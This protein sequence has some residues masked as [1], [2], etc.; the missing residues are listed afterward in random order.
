M[1]ILAALAINTFTVTRVPKSRR[2]T[3]YLSIQDGSSPLTPFERAHAAGVEG[4]INTAWTMK[5]PTAASLKKLTAENLAGLGPVR[6]A[7]ILLD[8]AETRP[9][10]KRRL[11]M[12]VAAEQGAEH[13]AP[14]IDKRL[15]SVQTSRGKIT[16][17]QKPAVV[18]DLDALRGLIAER[19]AGLDRSAALDRIWLFLETASS[20]E[21]RLRDRDGALSDVYVR[22]AGDLGRLLAEHD[23]QIGAHALIDAVAARP[24]AWGEWLPAALAGLPRAMAQTALQLALERQGRTPGWLTALRSLSDAAGDIQAFRATYTAEALATPG[25]AVEVARRFLAAQVV[26]EAGQVLRGAAPSPDRRGRL[27]PPNFDWETAWIDYL[28]ASGDAEAAQAVRWASFERT[29]DVER[30]R[31]FV[32][33]LDGFDD[34]EAENRAF[35]LAASTESFQQGLSFLMA[36][37]ALPEASQM[38]QARESEAVVDAP[39]AEVWAA[40]LRRRYPAAAHSLLRRAAAAA[41]RRRE[42]KL[43]DRLTEEAEAINL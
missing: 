20:V 42:F 26:E 29:L 16:W 12:E 7:D 34:V 38:V 39:E 23:P 1:A 9:D 43:C 13:L 27:P 14:Q 2:E 3:G 37:P 25:V 28:A 21:R 10:L 22:A 8:V 35:A 31:A 6:L 40:K 19:L 24:Q 41:F 17:R 36:W 11:R 33:Q 30:A 4:S 32:R 18:R 5:R 15:A